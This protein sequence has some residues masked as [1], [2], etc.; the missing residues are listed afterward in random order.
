[1]FFSVL[2]KSHTYK[3]AHISMDAYIL[4]VLYTEKDVLFYKNEILLYTFSL[5]S[6]FS[7][8]NT[9]KTT[10]TTLIYSFVTAP[11]LSQWMNNNLFNHSSTLGPSLCSVFR[12]SV[13]CT[14][15]LVHWCF[16]FCWVG[17]QSQTAGS[18][19]MSILNF[20]R[21]YLTAFPKGWNTQQFRQQ[22]LRWLCSPHEIKR[23]FNGPVHLMLPCC[24]LFF[25]FQKDVID[26]EWC[27]P[28]LLTSKNQEDMV[29]MS[30]TLPSLHP[31]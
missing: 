9:S 14:Y 12:F 29:Y 1:M 2:I 16:Y 3:H 4:Y 18:K 30:S 26:Y 11:Y 15:S 13:F 19:H 25:L 22:H 24:F 20:N 8:N 17:S 6:F 23:T 7:V 28:H 5:I 31:S 21:C 10:I 27:I